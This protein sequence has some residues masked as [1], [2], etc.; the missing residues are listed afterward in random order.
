MTTE[1]ARAVAALADREVEA[2]RVPGLLQIAGSIGSTLIPGTDYRVAEIREHWEPTGVE[3][4][5]PV[6]TTVVR[7]DPVATPARVAPS[8]GLEVERLTSALE[9]IRDKAMVAP[10]HRRL[11]RAI[12][13]IHG[14]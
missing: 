14:I 2:E 13:E 6:I 9:A 3:G 12:G 11:G 4:E 10:F 7:F 5:P 1:R 8:A